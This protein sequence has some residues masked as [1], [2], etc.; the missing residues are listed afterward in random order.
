M[1]CQDTD[2]IAYKVTS[3]DEDFD[4][5]TSRATTTSKWQRTDPSFPLRSVW[6]SSHIA[7]F[8]TDK[9]EE[10]RNYYVEKFHKRIDDIES[11]DDDQQHTN[12]ASVPV[13]ALDR[14]ANGVPLDATVINARG[15]K[16]GGSKRIIQRRVYGPQPYS[17][18]QWQHELRYEENPYD[19]ENDY[20][21]EVGGRPPVDATK[22]N[23]PSDAVEQL[24]ETSQSQEQRQPGKLT[25]PKG[26]KTP[27]ILEANPSDKGL[28]AEKRYANSTAE[29]ADTVTYDPN[30][31]T[32]EADGGVWGSSTWKI[33]SE[34]RGTYNYACNDL[35]I[36]ATCKTIRV[37]AKQLFPNL[38]SGTA[39]TGATYNH[40]HGTEREAKKD[41]YDLF[42]APLSTS[43]L[44]SR[45]YQLSITDPPVALPRAAEPTGQFSKQSPPSIFPR[46]M[47]SSSQLGNPMTNLP[48]PEER[49]AMIELLHNV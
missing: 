12:G 48:N 35:S 37:E 26:T 38:D 25:S 45:A 43:Q 41:F 17:L 4:L 3:E 40:Y 14:N 28:E 1:P 20:P 7:R 10:Y 24:V 16:R 9:L 15:Y 32:D 22:Q 23:Q 27:K 34:Y 2:Q 31:G 39:H 8:T 21:P 44:L 18:R 19:S 42:P 13:Q 29:E 5:V 36:L 46:T 30:D 11:N 33:T 47:L 6:I 49:M